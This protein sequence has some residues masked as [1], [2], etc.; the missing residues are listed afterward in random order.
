MVSY[1]KDSPTQTTVKLDGKV[2]GTISKVEGG[3]RYTPKG[4]K[5]GDKW[6]GAVL[7]T[8]ADVR[9]TL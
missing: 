8:E 2:T 5:V 1:T 9:A 3:W 7:P 4:K 6:S